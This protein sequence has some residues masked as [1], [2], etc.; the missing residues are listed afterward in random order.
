[1][2]DEAEFLIFIN[3]LGRLLNEYSLCPEESI[4]QMIDEDIKLLGRVLNYP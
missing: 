2:I 1:M 3:E 4:K